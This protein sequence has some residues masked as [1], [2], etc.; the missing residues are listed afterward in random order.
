[1]GYGCCNEI[2]T[3]SDRE[4]FIKEANKLAI[5]IAD[6]M[7]EENYQIFVKRD[8]YEKNIHW[9]M[10][11]SADLDYNWIT[12]IAIKKNFGLDIFINSAESKIRA[13]VAAQGYK[14]SLLIE[15][16]SAL[17]RAGVAKSGFGLSMLINDK[18]A[19]VRCAVAE[20]GYGLD[21]LI[22]DEDANVRRAV[23]EQSYET[24]TLVNDQSN[25]VRRGL[26]N[27]GYALEILMLDDDFYV[28][29]AAREKF[30]KNIPNCKN[31]EEAMKALE[32][33]AKLTPLSMNI[34]IPGIGIRDMVKDIDEGIAIDIINKGYCLSY[35][36]NSTNAWI[37][38]AVAK[39]GYGLDVLINDEDKRVRKEVAKQGYRL[40]VL[41]NDKDEWVRIAVA[42]QGYGLDV[43]I[44]D[45]DNL[46]RVYVV[47]QGYR[48]DVLV[49]DESSY[50]RQH[51]AQQGYRLDILVKDRDNDVRKEV[52]KQGYG[53]DI[54]VHDINKYVRSEVARQ[55]Y[56]LDILVNDEESR[57]KEAVISQGYALDTFL[58]DKGYGIASCA[59]EKIAEQYSNVDEVVKLVDSVIQT[60]PNFVEELHTDTCIELMNRGFPLNYFMKHR[61]RSVID[62]L[63]DRGYAL[64]TFI[65]DNTHRTRQLALYKILGRCINVDEVVNLVDSILKTD[66]DYL[67]RLSPNLCIVFIEKG[68]PLEYFSEHPDYYS[69]GV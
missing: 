43:L 53:L 34:N 55:G 24:D 47:E 61:H 33:I 58:Y 63:V 66:S 19:V 38:A 56:G 36:I 3:D 46:V 17:V 54:L 29:H 44:N 1:M 9:R 8:Y 26:A 35:F 32:Y 11:E 41:I 10:S 2:L 60:V 49:N 65:Y 40:D 59:L 69:L 51:V 7:T 28:S 45:K 37:R 39:Q 57:V 64:E 42:E 23:A 20:Q 12:F 14:S 27:S 6:E 62:A 13:A 18:E 16:K 4:F 50:V 67:N 31:N 48:L 22:D 21:I 68:C 15:D 25:W 5:K 30:L 52:A